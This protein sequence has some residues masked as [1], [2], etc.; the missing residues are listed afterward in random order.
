M[1]IWTDYVREWAAKKNLSYGCAISKPEIKIDYKRFKEQN[2]PPTKKQGKAESKERGS[3]GANDVNV[4]PQEY[5]T[6]APKKSKR[7][8]ENEIIKKKL[9]EIVDKLSGSM[10]KLVISM[11]NITKKNFITNKNKLI[12]AIRVSMETASQY[13]DKEVPHGNTYKIYENAYK[14]LRTLYN[15]VNGLNL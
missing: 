2:K 10:K 11:N 14:E 6:P 12:E 9:A 1:T 5:I 13:Q 4:Y 8:K 7:E 3:M 15:R